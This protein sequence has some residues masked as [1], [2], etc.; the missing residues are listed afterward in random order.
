MFQL[1]PHPMT[2]LCSERLVS[3]PGMPSHSALPM[4]AALALLG[5]MQA[6]IPMPIS[7][8]SSSLTID[9]TSFGPTPSDTA[10]L[11]LLL[12]PLND[13]NINICPLDIR[14]ANIF[15]VHQ[16]PK[17]KIEVVKGV[18]KML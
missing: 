16:T 6:P 18:L 9:T 13:I 2:D 4:E 8:Q 17:K 7:P 3:V 12:S 15:R 14:E 11:S 10:P 1:P 5:L